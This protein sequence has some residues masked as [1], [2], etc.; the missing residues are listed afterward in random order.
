MSVQPGPTDKRYAA[1][2]VSTIYTVPFLVIE[3]GDLNV[4]LNDVLMTSGYTHTGIG[5]PTSTLTFTTPPLGDLYLLLDVPFQ[6][7]TDYQENGD[8]LAETLNRDFDRI[9][10]ALKQLYGWASRSLRLGMFDVDG[11][12][13][14][15]AN[16]NGIRDLHDPVEQQD[17]ATRNSVDRAVS[18][19][20]AARAAADANLQ[21]QMS[22]S[23]PPVASPFSEISWHGQIVQSSVTIPPNKNAW[24]FGPVMSV[25]AGQVV[26]VSDGSFWTIADGELNP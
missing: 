12:G 23:I 10:Q 13:W 14:Y 22:G 20:A 26:T 1:N 7:L 9:W 17:A 15:R 6:R 4:Y 24:S 2:G 8:L 5:N 3:A 18:I 21:A 11:A 16:G 25:A 19:E